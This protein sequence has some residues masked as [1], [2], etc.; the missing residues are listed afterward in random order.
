MK[1]VKIEDAWVFQEMCCGSGAGD[2]PTAL[3]VL[4]DETVEE[5]ERV[6]LLQAFSTRA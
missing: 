1:I 6:A 3:A 5:W 4:R 2:P